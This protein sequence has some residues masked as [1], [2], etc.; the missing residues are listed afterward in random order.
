MVLNLKRYEIE[1]SEDIK[2]DVRFIDVEKFVTNYSHKTPSEMIAIVDF[3]INEFVGRIKEN[4]FESR[5]EGLGYIKELYKVC[6]LK[7]ELNELFAEEFY[8]KVLKRVR[9]KKVRK[10]KRNQKIIKKF[11]LKTSR[12][13]EIHISRYISPLPLGLLFFSSY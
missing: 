13:E 4:D 8:G 11:L 5:N 7:D 1:F 10:K 9:D 2:K 12:W 3:S 6:T